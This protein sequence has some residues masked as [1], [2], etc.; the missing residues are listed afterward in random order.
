MSQRGSKGLAPRRRGG[1]GVLK[2]LVDLLGSAA[3]LIIFSPFMLY[4]A[5]KIYKEDGRPVFY[6]RRRAG[7][8][9]RPFMLY[10][11]RTMTNERDARGNLLPD[12]RRITKFGAKLRGSSIDE[13]PQLLNVFRGEMSL[14]G[15]RP[16]PL[17]YVPLYGREQRR[18]LDVPQGITGWA[19]VNGRNALSWEERFALDLWYVENRSLPLD[20]KILLMTAAKVLRREGISAEGEAT[21]PRF[22]G[23]KHI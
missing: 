5:C 1:R 9:G 14:V 16:L 7:L 8:G 18:R 23:E 20:L 12:A 22:K 17:E 6:N 10:K 15:P 19:Q 2:R 21:M 3:G 11:F 4:A 13:L